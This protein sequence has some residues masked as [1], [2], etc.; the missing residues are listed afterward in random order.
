MANGLPLMGVLNQP[1]YHKD[2]RDDWRGR[3]IWGVATNDCK[4]AC[5]P[6]RIVRG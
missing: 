1:F 2:L 5:I 4:V 6:N 3:V